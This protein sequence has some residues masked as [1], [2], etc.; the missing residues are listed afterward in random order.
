MSAKTN[1]RV[2][3]QLIAQ[4]RLCR[5]DEHHRPDCKRCAR[6]RR[7]FGRERGVA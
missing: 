3:Q 4:R 2:L 1:S 7:H 5:G 6:G